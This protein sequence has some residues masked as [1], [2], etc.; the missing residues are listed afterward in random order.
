MKE[1]DGFRQVSVIGEGAFGK[2]YKA[3]DQNNKCVAVK[4]IKF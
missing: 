3:I 4:Y 1:I 2:V